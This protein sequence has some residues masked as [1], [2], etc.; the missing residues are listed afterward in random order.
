[1]E[2]DQELE[3]GV[4]RELEIEMR[5]S[6]KSVQDDPPIAE[7]IKRAF[8]WRLA[9]SPAELAVLDLC[10]RPVDERS[11]ALDE[12]GRS[13]AGVMV[14]SAARRLAEAERRT[15]ATLNLEQNG[16]P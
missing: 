13:L 8:D 16:S 14:V 3:Q 15:L 4:G 9:P 11:A 5:P 10:V 1:M 6:G 7:A 2:R 12:V